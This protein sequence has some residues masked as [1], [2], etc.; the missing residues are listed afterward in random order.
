VLFL[1]AVRVVPKGP[2]RVEPLD[3][4]QINVVETPAG[5]PIA[6]PFVV[7]PDGT[8]NLGFDYGSVRV[9]GLTLEQAAEAVRQ[10]LMKRAAIANPQVTVALAAFRGL[11]QI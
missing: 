6:G 10:H 1:E 9:R 11:Q 5:K 3:V 2:Y 7:S 8:L 4:L